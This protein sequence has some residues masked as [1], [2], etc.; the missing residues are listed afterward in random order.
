MHQPAIQAKHINFEFRPNGD[1]CTNADARWL[2][3]ALGNILGNALKFTPEHGSVQLSIDTDETHAIVCTKD[4]GMG[5]SSSFLPSIFD[6]FTQAE[7]GTMRSYGGLGIG[8]SIARNIIEAH[9]GRIEAKSEGLNK[10]AHF[11]VYLPLCEAPSSYQNGKHASVSAR[12]K[13]TQL[14][15]NLRVLVVEDDSDT[16]EMLH[17]LLEKAGAKVADAP[18]G[19]SA[20]QVL[21]NGSFDVLV[22]DVGLPDEDG[23]VLMR[24]VRTL[25]PQKNGRIPS[26]ALTAFGNDD[27]RDDCLKAGFNL[28]LVK[29]INP[30][31]LLDLVKKA[32]SHEFSAEPAL[33]SEPRP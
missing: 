29:P 31:Q 5:I 26:I 21:Q 6:Y 7:T 30:T 27:V 13:K 23:K 33:S 10:G 20:Y 18:N 19:Q 1:A 25:D 28:H 15:Q 3:R 14:L 22:S 9:G 8:L 4:S 12:R 2:Q 11:C 17:F 16:R 24:R 32:A